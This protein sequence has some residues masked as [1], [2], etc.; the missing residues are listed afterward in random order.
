MGTVQ[1]S[2][3]TKAAT[4]LSIPFRES[5]SGTSRP[6]SRCRRSPSP[7]GDPAH[8]C[9][10]S[11][12]AP[13]RPRHHGRA[14][15]QGSREAAPVRPPVLASEHQNRR[16][17][18]RGAARSDGGR[19]GRWGGAVAR[20]PVRP[21][22]RALQGLAVVDGWA[23][24]GKRQLTLVRRLPGVSRLP[25]GVGDLS[26]K[27][28]DPV[29]RRPGGPVQYMAQEGTADDG[30]HALPHT[31]ADRGGICRT[32]NVLQ[33][34]GSLADCSAAES[35]KAIRARRGPGGR[36]IR[37]RPGAGRRAARGGPRA[38]PPTVCSS[39]PRANRW[40]R[41]PRG[42]RRAGWRSRGA[43]LRTHAARRRRQREPRKSPGNGLPVSIFR[44]WVSGGWLRASGL[45]MVWQVSRTPARSV[46]ALQGEFS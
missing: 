42:R 13:G 11:R 26:H 16:A 33:V 45:P 31:N 4:A 25:Y 14:P 12:A 34:V 1:S 29:G 19:R 30:K 3:D 21:P 35:E 37:R 2:C 23:D 28:Q 40:R 38:A 41:C 5:P 43:G 32:S 44:G 15:V 17:R 22:H 9:G 24:S 10:E 36:G 39:R 20:R 27:K 46:Y 8:G 6:H 18:V 7:E